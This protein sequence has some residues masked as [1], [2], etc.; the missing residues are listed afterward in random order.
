MFGNPETQPGGRA[1]K[2]YSSVRLDI[3]RTESLKQGTDVIGSR[4]KVRVVKNKVAPP[5]RLAEFDILYSRGHLQGRQPPRRRHRAGHRQEERRLPLLRRYAR[6]ARA[7]RTPASSS[8]EPRDGRRD[9]APDPRADRRRACARAHSRPGHAARRRRGALR[10]ARRYTRSPSVLAPP[11]PA[12]SARGR[13]GP[14]REMASNA[15][16]GD[17]HTRIRK[18]AD[19]TVHQTPNRRALK[20]SRAPQPAG[21]WSRYRLRPTVVTPNFSAA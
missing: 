5:F 10:R 1:L 19:S 17:A 11:L 3:R 8:P 21:Y 12:A 13:R 14:R 6:S 2:F 9:R 7:G 15:S 18:L 4:A 20:H 16:V